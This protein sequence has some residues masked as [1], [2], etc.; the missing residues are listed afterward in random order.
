MTQKEAAEALLQGARNTN[1][2]HLTVV[3]EH[4]LIALGEAPEDED[5]HPDDQPA[6]EP[7]TELS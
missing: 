5:G 3:R 1:C 4:L 7:T 2:Q 6:D